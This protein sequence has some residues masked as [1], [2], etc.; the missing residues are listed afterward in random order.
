MTSV[1]DVRYEQCDVYIGR[2][3][4]RWAHSKWANPFHVGRDGTRHQVIVKY[5]EHIL[6]SPH[7]MAALPELKNKVLGCWCHGLPCHGDVLVELLNA[8]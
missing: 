3:C 1:V 8:V 5:R 7:L 4:G 6:A 2:K